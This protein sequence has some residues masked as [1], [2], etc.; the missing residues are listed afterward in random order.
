MIKGKE[1]IHVT[2]VITTEATINVRT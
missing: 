2:I 1:C